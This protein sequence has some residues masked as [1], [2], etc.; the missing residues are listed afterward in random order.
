MTYNA[1]MHIFITGA[2]GLLGSRLV[3]KLLD[4]QHEVTIVS[5][6]TTRAKKQ[7]NNELVNIIEAD[8][9]QQGEWQKVASE[10]DAI[11]HLAGAGIVDRRWTKSYKSI[12]RN[13]RIESTTR[14]AQVAN[15][16]LICASAIGFYGDCGNQQLTEESPSGNDFLS[17]LCS[18]WESAAS[19][20]HARVVSL[21]FGI[22]LDAKSGALAKM[23]PLFR[24]GLGGPIGNGKQY[25]PWIAWQ[26]ACNVIFEAL[27][28]DWEGPINAVAPEQVT[29]KEFVRTLGRVMNKPSFMKVP[30][31]AL[32]TIIGE[33]SCALTGSQRV[34]PGVLL[35]QSFQFKYP[36]LKECLV[37]NL[38][39]LK[40]E[41]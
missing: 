15:N 39:T 32:R 27:H 38:I 24:F 34:T 28:Q 25:W 20:A 40:K 1:P 33:G 2:T 4:F 23:L 17:T 3:A 8:I 22:I 16:I 9:T 11:V 18:E 30:A 19:I 31:F 10:C 13:S 35:E 7:F 36:T 26:D 5:R 12:I 41:R 29:C 21:R 37:A 6:N 14:V